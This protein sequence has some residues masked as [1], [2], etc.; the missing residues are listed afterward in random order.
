MSG[1]EELR[2]R[3]AMRLLAFDT[4][5]KGLIQ[6]LA[7]ERAMPQAGRPR[8]QEAKATG[9]ISIR[10]TISQHAGPCEDLIGGGSTEGIASNL[11]AFLADDDISKIV[12]DIDSPGG[13]SYGVAELAA[14]IMQSRG[15]KPI[16]AVSNSLAASAAYWIAAACDQVFVTPGGL[17]GSIG[18][19]CIHQDISKAADQAGLKVTFISA[20]K[21]KVDGNQFEPLGDEAQARVQARVDDVY[22]QFVR[23][24]ARGRGLPESTVKGG[25]G[26]GD[27]VT[28]KKA[29]SE[30]MADGVMTL[31]AVIAKTFRMVESGAGVTAESHL[32][33]L[34]GAEVISQPEG[35]PD[36]PEDNESIE[37]AD[38]E[39]R[40]ARFRFMARAAAAGAA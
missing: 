21:Y 23:D 25:F 36:D 9:V 33:T 2:A 31:D 12:L 11:R 19:Y 1:L 16:I 30:G 20:G 4:D 10:G 39:A 7:A 15:Q 26:E 22:G 40:S 6:T 27:V 13:T 32:G 18:V 24:V 5:T 37:D 3:V 35:E 34:F 8:T 14:E 17:V 38:P 28:A 29:V